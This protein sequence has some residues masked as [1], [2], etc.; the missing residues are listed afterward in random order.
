MEDIQAME[1]IIVRY[2]KT[3][4]FNGSLLTWAFFIFT[5]SIT[6]FFLVG[7]FVRVY[8]EAKIFIRAK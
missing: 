3:L 7:T 5:C 1:P 2:I 8:L 6:P 4:I